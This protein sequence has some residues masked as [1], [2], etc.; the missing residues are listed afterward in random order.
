MYKSILA[1]AITMM[2]AT[3]PLAGATDNTD[4]SKLT[5]QGDTK[6]C[7]IIETNDGKT[8]VINVPEGS[9][10]GTHFLTSPVDLTP[11]ENR[12]SAIVIR[13][14]WSNV[15]KPEKNYLGVKFML[16][17]IGPN[18]LPVWK[19]PSGLFGNSDWKEISTTI[20]PLGSEVHTGKLI[21]GLQDSSGQVEFD[22]NS[23]KIVPLYGYDPQVGDD[24]KISYPESLTNSPRRRGVMVRNTISEEDFKTLKEWNVNLIRFQLTRNW[25]KLNTDLDL[26]EYDTWINGKLDHLEDVLKWAE[27]SGIKVVIDL[28]SPPGGRIE[29][30][31]MRMFTEKKYFDHYV[32][33]WKRIATRFNG[34]KTVWAYDLINEP[35]QKSYVP[36]DYWTVQRTAAEAVRAIDPTTPIMVESNNWASASAYQYLTPLNLDNVI[37]H[38]HMYNPGGF[39]HQGVHKNPR[40]ATYP[41]KV[42]GIYYDK[43]KLRESLKPVRDFQLKHHA[44][45]YVGEFSA[46][47]WAPGAN[48]Y[49]ADCIAIF[50]EYGWDWSYHAFRESNIWS[51]ELEGNDTKSLKPSPDNP[52]KRVL[53]EAFK[54]NE[55]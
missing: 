55:H 31:V 10:K 12:S 43:E 38:V 25:G 20:P 8:A 27:A 29:G 34:N 15:S 47:I 37:Y 39:T 11:L 14:R 1:L 7:Q 49:L 28:H 50:E 19:H 5:W 44:R 18:G 21:L 17:Y 6:F 36:F 45:I 3:L 30:S 48:R 24:Y 13:A 54:L 33:V 9:E 51:V 23:L 52:R 53:L 26:D 22:L 46:A 16:N 41:G 4:Y 32:E 35:V 40:G 42:K 2:V